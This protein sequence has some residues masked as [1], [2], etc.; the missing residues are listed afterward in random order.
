VD[1][2]K[3][4][5]RLSD[6]RPTEL[7]PLNICL[8]IN[9]DDEPSKSGFSPQEALETAV[10]I[11]TMPNL[12]LRGLMAIPKPS[13]SKAEQRQ[14]F[15]QLRALQEQINGMLDN[16]QKLDTLSM[17]MS[18]DLEPAIHEGATIV[19]VGTDIFGPRH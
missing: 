4:A 6:Q 19:R 10:S 14:P 15:A 3:I 1:R 8:Q 18:G 11:A 13:A 16:S 12:R 5:K 17:G 7:G 9:I 2:L